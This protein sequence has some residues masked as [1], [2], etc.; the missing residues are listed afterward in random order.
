MIWEVNARISGDFSA[1]DTILGFK[2][3][4]ITLQACPSIL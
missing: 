4:S 2:T 3:T 1:V